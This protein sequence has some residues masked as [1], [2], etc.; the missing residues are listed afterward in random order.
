MNEQFTQTF[1]DTQDLATQVQAASGAVAPIT[2][3]ED[4]RRVEEELGILRELKKHPKIKALEDLKDDA[5]QHIKKI[6]A[7]LNDFTAPIEDAI[8]ARSNAILSYRRRIAAEAERVAAEERRKEQQRQEA[9]AKKRAAEAIADG[10]FGQARQILNQPPPP[11]P[12]VVRRTAPVVMASNTVAERWHAEITNLKVLVTA[13]LESDVP[14]DAVIEV[15]LPYFNRLATDMKR[16]DLGFPG[17]IGVS[18]A[19][20]RRK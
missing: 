14:L 5:N 8:S 6:R 18:E 1:P 4:L 11:P 3:P 16:K 10:N 20:L 9:E 17:V 12:P 13:L 7:L 2:T 15:K 19:H